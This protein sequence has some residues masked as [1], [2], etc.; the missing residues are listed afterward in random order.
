MKRILLIWEL[1]SNFGHLIRLRAIGDV[2]ANNGYQLLFV[3]KDSGLAAEWLTRFG[4]SFVE[5]PTSKTIRPLHAPANFAEILIAEGFADATELARKI[6]AWLSLF[7]SYAPAIVVLD[8]APSALLASRLAAIPA[9]EIG[10]GFELPPPTFPLPSIR[11]WETFPQTRVEASESLALNAINQ[12][13][14]AHRSP[15][16]ETLGD[17]F[18]TSTRLFTTFAE[19]DHYGARAGVRYIGQI[20]QNNEGSAPIW[21]FPKRRSVFIYMHPNVPGFF[22]LMSVLRETKLEV[23]CVAPGIGLET[24]RTLQSSHCVIHSSFVALAQL[25]RTADLVICYGG[26]GIVTTSLLHGIPL[27]LLPQYVEQSLLS[28]RVAAIG[29]GVVA[30]RDRTPNTLGRLLNKIMRNGAC[31]AHAHAFAAKYRGWT[32][33]IALESLLC[34]IKLLA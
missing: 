19:L 24:A 13:I 29:A 30:G 20:N 4:Y 3:V 17:L 16:L 28:R 33:D 26:T 11:P 34:E 25:L 21:R 15:P 12:V 18:R 1:G 31:Q 2:L 14:K 8:Y 27:L 6:N 10:G 23:I 32:P 22:E 5:T 9:V 7:K